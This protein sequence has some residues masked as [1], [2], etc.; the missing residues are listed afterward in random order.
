[1]KSFELDFI[2]NQP[3]SQNLLQTVRAIG[4]YK[5]KQELFREQSP[6]ILETLQ[7]V[8]IIQS[9]ESSNRIEGIVTSSQ[10]IR[11]L[12]ERKT[13]PLNRSEQEIAGYRDILS[14]IHANHSGMI[15]APNLVLQM[16]RDLSQFLPN[17]GG[18]WKQSDNSITETLHDGTTRLRFQ[19]VPAYLTPDAMR[20][21]H[22]RFNAHLQS[23]DIEPLLLIATYILDFLCIH[24][25]L[26]GNGRMVRLITLLLLYMS[27]YEVGHYVSLESIIERS[28]ESYYDTLYK[29]SQGWHES[30]YSLQPWL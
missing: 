11:Q 22:E 20:R 12:V 17:S 23:R 28:R 30:K 2:E 16:H 4:E 25:F 14:T 7:Q 26:D 10:R 9:T 13:T 8:A 21:L 19:P 29:S 6:Q 27:G 15:F 3:I 24:P 1:V 18:I 5:G